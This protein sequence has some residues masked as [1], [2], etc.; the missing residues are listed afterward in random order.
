MFC[1][2]LLVRACSGITFLKRRF[3]RLLVALFGGCGYFGFCLKYFAKERLM[4]KCSAD[5]ARFKRACLLV[6][7]Y[8]ALLLGA[9]QVGI[10]GTISDMGAYFISIVSMLIGAL[11]IYMQFE[12]NQHSAVIFASLCWLYITEWSLLVTGNLFLGTAILCFY[13]KREGDDLSLLISCWLFLFFAPIYFIMPVLELISIIIIENFRE[14][15]ADAKKCGWSVAI[16]DRSIYLYSIFI[17]VVILGMKIID[18]LC[19]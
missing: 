3:W 19:E 2:V 14:I 11:C 1:G 6:C 17:S 9:L 7:C 4:L 13:P 8:F 16:G 12:S 10:T 5:V 15:I 18:I